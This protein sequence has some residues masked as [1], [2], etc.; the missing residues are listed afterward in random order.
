[1]YG[2]GGSP[3]SKS[4]LPWPSL[5]SLGSAALVST[6]TELAAASRA[7]GVVGVAASDSSKGG[8]GP[9]G[10]GASAVSECDASDWVT[11]SQYGSCDDGAGKYLEG[12][13]WAEKGGGDSVAEDL[14][15]WR[16]VARTFS[17]PECE[18]TSSLGAGVGACPRRDGVVCTEEV[19]EST[20]SVG[21]L[22]WREAQQAERVVLL[23]CMWLEGRVSIVIAAWT[24]EQSWRRVQ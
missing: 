19:S 16:A 10:G 3:S 12:K 17:R 18:S 11:S 23:V 15:S 5:V 14:L 8:A 1:V 2:G 13:L 7:P 21:L 22:E 24:G 6:R 20:V 4:L 9:E